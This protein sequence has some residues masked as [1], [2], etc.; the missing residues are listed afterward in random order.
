MVGC[1][2]LCV[3]EWVVLVSPGPYPPPEDCDVSVVVVS[4][5]DVAGGGDS[6]SLFRPW[7]KV[8]G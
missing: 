6:R 1:A 8:V 5:A 2:V 7:V 3:V 4:E